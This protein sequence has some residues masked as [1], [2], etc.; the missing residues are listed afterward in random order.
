MYH[1]RLKFTVEVSKQFVRHP[2]GKWLTVISPIIH[3][4]SR[5]EDLWF[6]MLERS[7]RDANVASF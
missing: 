5:Y 1:K 7:I 2:H 3:I 4:F 6:S